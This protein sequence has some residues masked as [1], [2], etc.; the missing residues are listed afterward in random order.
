M[1]VPFPG[2]KHRRDKGG[3]PL[4]HQA[5]DAAHYHA[6]RQGTAVIYEAVSEAVCS[7]RASKPL[8]HD[9]RQRINEDYHNR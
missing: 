7:F 4:R 2:R 3:L 6:D 1:G 5:R 8:G 9:W